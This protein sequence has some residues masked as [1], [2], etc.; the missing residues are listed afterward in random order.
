M[1]LSSQ[2]LA[3]TRVYAQDTQPTDE[4]DGIIWVDT[5]VSPRDTF[6]YSSASNSWELISPETWDIQNTAPNSP[7]DGDGW[8]D[9]SVNPPKVNVYNASDA[10]W[11][12]YATE[13]QLNN[14]ITNFNNHTAA[15]EPHHTRPT[16]T[17]NA[18]STTGYELPVTH[19]NS[20]GLASGV[21]ADSYDGSTTTYAVLDSGSNGFIDYDVGGIADGIRVNSG[22]GATIDIINLG[23]NSVLESWNHNGNGWESRIFRTT[24]SNI[25]LQVNDT[26]NFRANEVEFNVE[27]PHSH[28]I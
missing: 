20:G 21:P 7:S 18:L 14:H 10:T 1:G 22:G 5:S 11:R 23:D 2:T 27:N 28:S 12:P 3:D 24:N 26:T 19:V 9:T 17:Q 4:R 6:V 25:R 15:T 16:T 8:I 13:N